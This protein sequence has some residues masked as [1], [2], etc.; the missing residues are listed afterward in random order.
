VIL[1]AKQIIGYENKRKNGG[2]ENQRNNIRKLAMK[3]S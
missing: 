1:T 3:A 2:S